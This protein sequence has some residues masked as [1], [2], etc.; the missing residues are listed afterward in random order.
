MS[1][2]SSLVN[3]VFG[4]LKVTSE[5]I[6][7]SP[8]K[9]MCLCVCGR[10]IPVLLGNL[11]GREG[12]EIPVSCGCLAKAHKK[13]AAKCLGFSHTSLYPVWH[14]MVNRCTDPR[15]KKYSNYGGRGIG[16]CPEWLADFLVFRKW[17]MDQPYEKGLEID[18]K[19][20]DKG[21]GPDN[22]HFVPHVD[23]LHNTALLRSSNKSGFRGVSKRPYNFR[24]TVASSFGPKLMKSGFGTAEAAALARDVHC[25]K[26]DIPLPLNFPE[27]AFQ[28]PL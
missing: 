17:A 21:Y 7:A 12:R 13:Q 4:G 22:C 10:S 9:F 16:V 19:D 2:G 3:Q 8:R 11:R 27:L 18:R 23:N 28:G 20:N 24:A 26:H 1:S 6:G 14:N 25:L 5:I 15:N